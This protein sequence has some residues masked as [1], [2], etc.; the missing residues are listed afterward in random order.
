MLA[1]GP[2]SSLRDLDSNPD[3]GSALSLVSEGASCGRRQRIDPL[4]M[5][6]VG[7]NVLR[8]CHIP[9]LRREQEPEETGV[10]IGIHRSLSGADRLHIP[11]PLN[12]NSDLSP[13]IE[14]ALYQGNPCAALRCPMPKGFKP[15]GKPHFACIMAFFHPFGSETQRPIMGTP[16]DPSVRHLRPVGQAQPEDSSERAVRGARSFSIRLLQ[17]ADLPHPDRRPERRPAP[18]RRRHPQKYPRRVGDTPRNRRSA[19]TGRGAV[20]TN[21]CPTARSILR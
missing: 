11:L 10:S 5:A 2:P 7:A 17:E 16:C 12:E 15:C 20:A 4:R 13:R 1:V 3:S 6:E 21:L 14:L 8:R 18:S 19:R 9:V